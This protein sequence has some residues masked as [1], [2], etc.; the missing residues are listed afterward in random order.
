MA[1]AGMSNFPPPPTVGAPKLWQ[2]F[3]RP[4]AMLPEGFIL[5]SYSLASWDDRTSDEQVVE[6]AQ[7][8]AEVYADAV[9]AGLLDHLGNYIET[10]VQDEDGRLR[11]L[12]MTYEAYDI[13]LSRN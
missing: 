4:F 12:R 1:F 9:R 6:W 8:A 5:L 2:S 13:A 7:L 10:A 3:D 11:V